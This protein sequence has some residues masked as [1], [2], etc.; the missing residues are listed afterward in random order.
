MKTEIRILALGVKG[1]WWNK[2]QPYIDQALSGSWIKYKTRYLGNQWKRIN[3]DALDV[4]CDYQ[5]D[6]IFTSIAAFGSGEK[7][8]NF[9]H[10]YKKATLLPLPEIF[11]VEKQ[12]QG[13][14][15]QLWNDSFSNSCSIAGFSQI[16][17][18]GIRTLLEEITAEDVIP[19]DPDPKLIFPLESLSL[20]EN[21][22]QNQFIS[23]SE[24][25]KID[26]KGREYDPYSFA[27]MQINLL[28]L[29]PDE[30]RYIGIW[31]EN[32]S[33]S[34]ISGFPLQNVISIEIKD[35]TIAHVITWG[36]L[37]KK[38][39]ACESMAFKLQQRSLQLLARSCDNEVLF[40]EAQ[41]KKCVPV[42][43][44]SEFELTRRYLK[45]I[46]HK[47]G[48][49]NVITTKELKTETGKLL[50]NIANENLEN[51]ENALQFPVEEKIKEIQGFTEQ[52]EE[53]N[54]FPVPKEEEVQSVD[55]KKQWSRGLF[56]LKKI[57]Q[58]LQIIASTKIMDEQDKK[59]D[60][61]LYERLRLLKQL[62]DNAEVWENEQTILKR[63]HGESAFIFYDDRMQ[64][65]SI[66]PQLRRVEKR[67]H[68]NIGKVQELESLLQL[69]EQIMKPFLEEGI[70]ICCA[71]SKKLLSGKLN[72]FERVLQKNRYNTYNDEEKKLH[73]NRQKVQRIIS[74][75]MSMEI[76][77]S[78]MHELQIN[79]STIY[80]ES[81]K[82][83]QQ[84]LT[85]SYAKS[86]ISTICISSQSSVSVGNLINAILNIFP[87][88]EIPE[89]HE[90]PI[91]LELMIETTT[92]SDT[93]ETDQ[94]VVLE[95]DKTRKEKELL[96]YNLRIIENF[97][98]DLLKTIV[99]KETDLL[100]WVGDIGLLYQFVSHIKQEMGGFLSIPV[101]GIVEKE[102]DP[103]KYQQ[104]VESGIKLLYWDQ[105][106]KHNPEYLS[107]QMDLLLS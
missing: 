34:M 25:E 93:T 49:F 70:L 5:P 12:L 38:D 65:T 43:I 31:V 52:L 54:H 94:E 72:E 14:L 4:C 104:A 106:N 92:L 101:I 103:Q 88:N 57:D 91:N 100:L 95:D 40:D 32:R 22:S 50:L 9:F 44:Y 69:D 59:S 48:Y 77:K 51:P 27:R 73:D 90:I 86:S 11:L 39:L 85:T 47:A 53:L 2:I 37:R 20:F 68:F 87:E 56:H 96:N 78:I 19:I 58:D 16:S 13:D 75:L 35:L 71:S 60:E 102:Y 45:K 84:D 46:L 24:V 30:K 80:Q 98:R 74:K 42:R 28:K 82:I 26:W 61:N 29:D 1:N 23:F 64:L 107:G 76:W 18:P 15:K 81:L 63:I 105:F 33:F 36:Q 55:I 83:I 97:Q 10:D 3:D 99:S 7:L 89:I 62:L 41:V 79:S 6:F 67:F 21:S 17:L 8:K 66:M